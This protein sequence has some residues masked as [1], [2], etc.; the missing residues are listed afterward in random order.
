MLIF[1]AKLFPL[2]CG[3]YLCFL[4]S[5]YMLELFIV[6]LHRYILPFVVVVV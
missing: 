6:S 4:T 3:N 1:L 2:N 5:H